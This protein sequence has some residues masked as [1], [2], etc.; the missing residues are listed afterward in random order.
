MGDVWAV[1]KGVGAVWA[2]CGRFL[3]EYFTVWAV[4]GRFR[5]F[6]H[7]FGHT[8]SQRVAL[9]IVSEA[10]FGQISDLNY[11]HIHVHVTLLIQVYRSLRL[12]QPPNGLGGQI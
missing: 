6:A 11:P 10:N 2:M 1:F 7:T 12:L 9:C 5:R 3:R 8:S 4:C